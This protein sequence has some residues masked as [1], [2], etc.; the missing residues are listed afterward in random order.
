MSRA[1][2]SIDIIVAEF[3]ELS[4]QGPSFDD[5]LDYFSRLS[6]SYNVILIDD[7]STDGS[8]ERIVG[9][10][11]ELNP[12]LRLMRMEKNGKK[13]Q[14]VRRGV[15][16]SDADY[17]FLSDFDSRIANPEE[18]PTV[19]KRFEEEPSLGGVSVKLVPEGDSIFSRF[20]DLEYA[21][22]RGV[23]ARYLNRQGRLRCVPGAAGI[24]RREVFLQVIR[25][26]SGKHS[27][28][29][30]ESTAIALRRGYSTEY[31][32]E[33]VVSTA[34][35]QSYPAFFQQRSRW[36]LGSLETYDKERRFFA[37][38]A[39]NLR[40]RLGHVT[41]LDWYAW[42]SAILYPVFILNWVF[43]PRV[44]SAYMTLEVSLALL[45]G[46]LSRNEVRSKKE[47]LLAPLFPLYRLMEVIPRFAAALKFLA[48]RRARSIPTAYIPVHSLPI[49]RGLSVRQVVPIPPIEGS[50]R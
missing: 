22:S 14:A 3:N 39:K 36:E 18:I 41:L 12:R 6:E 38:Q 27:G 26:H 43:E 32:G 35:P 30:L 28:D 45:M 17:I 19:L 24:W 8:W 13:V 4:R 7:A 1:N 50:R 49:T 34:V 31:N 42:A 47:L 48:G 9:R 16:R 23:F 11:H 37:G 46:Y 15:E 29:D 25:E 40:N 10:S 2:A 33:V 21:I 5:Q 44:A 20:Q